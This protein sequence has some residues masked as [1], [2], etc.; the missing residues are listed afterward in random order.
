M[1]KKK[2]LFICGSINQTTQMHQVAQALPEYDN[3][4][5]PYYSD[6]FEKALYR[7]GLAEMTVMGSKLMERCLGYLRRHRLAIDNGGILHNYDLVVTCSDLVVQKNIRHKKIIL[8]Q[9]GMTDKENFAY[10]LVRTLP[11][12]PRWIA[13]TSTNGLSHAYH[14]FCVASEGYRDFFIGKGVDP[15]KIRVTGIPNFDHCERFYDNDFPHKSFVLVCT[16][17][18]RETFRYENRKKFIKN[19]LQVANGRQLIFKLHPNENVAKATAEINRWAPDALIFHT[20]SAEH[21]IAN[22]DVLITRFSSTA[23]VGLA[24]GKEV[25]SD[26]PLEQLRRLMPVQNKGASA[27]NIADVV[28]D[29]M[30]NSVVPFRTRNAGALHPSVLKPAIRSYTARL[31]RKLRSLDL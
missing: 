24:L 19:A 7:A 2:I 25:Y 28:R 29:E 10:H 22:S 9:E 30:E 26:F 18:T 12:L 31:Q 11:F 4:F 21:M 3:W 17:D 23:Y 27:R 13:G 15:A 6:G 8:L 20:G 5:T 16:S 14:K 1:T